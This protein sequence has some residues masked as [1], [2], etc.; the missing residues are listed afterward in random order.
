MIAAFFLGIIVNLSVHRKQYQQYIKT[1]RGLKHKKAITIKG[2]TEFLYVT[3]QIAAL[4]WVSLSY[5]IAIIGTIKYGA[6]YPVEDL[7]EQAIT[8]ILGVTVMKTVGNIFE[9]NEG[10]LLGT[11]YKEDETDEDAKG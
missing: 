1:L 5:I 6:V 10:K 11:S 8:A 9:H 3:T 2:I 4:I 7:S